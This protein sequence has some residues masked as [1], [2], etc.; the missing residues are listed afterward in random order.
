LRPAGSCRPT[1]IRAPPRAQ[2]LIL[3][4]RVARRRAKALLALVCERGSVHPRE[5]DAQL[6]HGAIENYWG[7]TF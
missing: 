5:G 7:G 4:P 1:P 3:R 2:D 6:A